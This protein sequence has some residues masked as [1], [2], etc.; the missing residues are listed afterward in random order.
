VRTRFDAAARRVILEVADRGPGVS[1]ELRERIFEPFFTTKPVGQGTGLGLPVCKRIVENHGGAIGVESRPGEGAVF[2]VELPAEVV[3]GPRSE[4]GAPE[5]SGAAAGRSILI[6]DDEHEVAEVLAELLR[7][8][9]HTVEI[10]K[11]GLAG[12]QRLAGVR[13]DLV[14]TDMKMPDLDG[15]A[16]H[17]EAERLDPSLPGRFVFM[18]GDGL[19]DDTQEFLSRTGRPTLRKPFGLDEAER[20]VQE[21]V[22][23]LGIARPPPPGGSGD[24]P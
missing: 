12:L 4:A 1:P 21:A 8:V 14:I 3:E 7:S 16:L 5:T 17:R 24:A 23:A 6:V 10:A 22:R 13:F 2:R 15:R 20:V 18:T 11:G 19:S 9:G